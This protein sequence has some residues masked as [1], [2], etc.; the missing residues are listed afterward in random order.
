MKRE[1]VYLVTKSAGYEI[2]DGPQ[3]FDYKPELVDDYL[4]TIIGTITKG[5]MTVALNHSLEP[6]GI[7]GYITGLYTTD[8]I[9]GWIRVQ[10]IEINRKYDAK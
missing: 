1:Y 4:N 5:K 7:E 10:A 3:V 9:D 2:G 6:N 8:I